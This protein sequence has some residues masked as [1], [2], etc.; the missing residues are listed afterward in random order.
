MTSVHL[1]LN[2]F[3][4]QPLFEERQLS[5]LQA[6][7]NVHLPT[8]SARLVAAKDEDTEGVAVNS[9]RTLSGRS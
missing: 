8:W 6:L 3:L 5:A 4:E 9:L 1:W 2:F 7:L